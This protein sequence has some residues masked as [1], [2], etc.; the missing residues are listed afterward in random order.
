VVLYTAAVSGLARMMMLSESSDLLL[1]FLVAP[2][3]LTALLYPRLVYLFLALVNVVA[4]ILV[5]CALYVRPGTPLI[6][7]TVVSTVILAVCEMLHRLM[8]WRLQV[9]ERLRLTSEK[10]RTIVNAAPVAIIATDPEANVSMWN[11]AAERIFGWTDAEVLG[12][13]LPIIPDEKQAESRSYFEMGM[14]GESLS[15]L[16]ARRL[17]KSGSCIDV[18]LSSAPLLDDSGSVDGII[19]V[20]DDVSPRTRAERELRE[21]EERFRSLV[22]NSTDV[23]AILD[24]G[25]TVRYVSPAVGKMLG[26][27]PRELLRRPALRA[28]HPKDVRRVRR[29]FRE[30]I[31]NPGATSSIEFRLRDW[32]GAWR[33][34]KTVSQNL[35]HQPS[36]RG[37][38]VNASDITE[39]K[40]FEEE[41]F[42][43]AFYDAATDLPNRTLF[44]D[45]LKQAMARKDRRKNG[46]AVMFLDLDR[47]KVIND[48]L[49]H[50]AG[51]DLLR[52]VGQ[53]LNGCLREGDTI[54]RFGG[55]EFTVLLSELTGLQEATTIAE[56]IIRSLT[57]PFELLGREA[58]IS[59]SI[60]IAQE[61]G[62]QVS[63]EGLLRNADVALYRAKSAGKACYVVFDER[64]SASAAQRLDLESYLHQAVER[65][66]LEL[67]Y[68]PEVELRTGRIIGVEAVLRWAHPE[69]GLLSPGTFLPIAE[70][71]GLIV[72]IG[73]WAREQA[74]RQAAGWNEGRGD[75]PPLLMSVNL[76]P[77]EFQ[78]PDFVSSLE[79]TLLETAVDPATIRVEIT[80]TMLL[81][82]TETAITTLHAL[83]ELGLQVA[84]DDFGTGYSSLG[85]LRRLPVDVLKIDQTFVSELHRDQTSRSIVRAIIALAQALNIGVTAEGVETREQLEELLK[86][87]CTTGQG[88]YFA[89]PFAAEEMPAAA[90]SL[91]HGD[92]LPRPSNDLPLADICRAPGIRECSNADFVSA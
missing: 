37:I 36:V 3:L 45:R 7:V 43:Q 10:L 92:P 38:V 86:A 2:V 16:E 54:A 42:R 20:I 51:D 50:A 29:A 78:Q 59:V 11:P 87:G 8:L 77:R 13:E 21:S 18:S 63:P 55:D 56:G 89:R 82:D 32:E 84:I 76:S 72:P 23:V 85:Y 47:F 31:A 15:G 79:R 75:L 88:Y 68:Q 61:D 12:R 80:E 64:M 5:V 19:S 69:Q 52:Q 48:V 66:E 24:E 90:C 25:A 57:A 81:G 73:R 91:P 60:G 35:L 4:S 70:E 71:T 30:L 1:Y 26:Y 46:V 62:E 65:G 28:I 34:I 33:Q 74:C 17:T 49:G 58:F 40:Q 39:S 83:K 67:H 44:M 22:Q 27:S 6:T 9:E 14:R 53:R 41:L